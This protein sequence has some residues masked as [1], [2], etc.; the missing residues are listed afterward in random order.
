MFQILNDFW[1]NKRGVFKDV[2][3]PQDLWVPD[4]WECLSDQEKA[5]F[6]FFAAVPMRGGLISEDPFKWLQK[7]W[8]MFPEFFDVKIVSEILTPDYMRRS[9]QAVTNELLDGPGIGQNGAGSLSYKMEEHI[10]NWIANAKA[11][12]HW[13]ND[14][15]LNVFR[16]V[17]D[18]EEGF[19][20]IDY[21]KYRK[22][23]ERKARC[24]H[25]IRRKIFSLLT[26]WF[27][28]KNLVPLF[29]TPIPV[30]FHAMRILWQTN[31]IKPN[32]W[33]HLFVPTKPKHSADLAGKPSVRVWE[34]F[35]DQIALWSQQFLQ[36]IGIS[37]MVINPAL[38]VLSRTL[39]AEH[40]QTSSLNDGQTFYTAEKLRRNPHLWSKNRRNPCEFCPVEQFCNGCIPANPYYTDGFL[41]KIERV[42]HTSP[43][44]SSVDWKTFGPTFKSR[45][46]KNRGASRV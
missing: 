31:I 5:N 45:K 2:V 18:F 10:P 1:T 46:N 39:C 40:L 22:R 24:F 11:L 8:T 23:D 29:P 36:K 26:I 33:K 16:D 44:F 27:Q 42:H 7:L 38:W 37:H 21:A 17:N 41:V 28:E 20:L 43:R 6:F 15:V 14:D 35:T 12:H 32:N 25:G 19:K 3:L 4:G 34:R 30:D 9:I 13:W